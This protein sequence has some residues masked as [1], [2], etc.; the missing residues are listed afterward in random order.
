[1]K[2]KVVTVVFLLGIICTVTQSFASDFLAINDFGN[3]KWQLAADNKVYFRNLNDFDG[4]YLSCCYNFY[5]D[6][7]STSGKSFFSAFLTLH[8]ASQ[9]G[10]IGV[11]NKGEAGAINYIGRW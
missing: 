10:Y 8:A 1:M 11:P 9:S 4:N 3:I 2:R 5:I 7:T 6:L